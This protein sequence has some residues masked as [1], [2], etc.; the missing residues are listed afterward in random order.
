MN[1]IRQL[2]EKAR[3]IRKLVITSV[4]KA[5]S[6]HPGG[7]LSCADLMA[8]LYFEVMNVRPEEPRWEDRDRFVLS[9]GHSCPALYAA[10]A[11]R[12][13]FPVKELDTLRCLGSV[14][15]GHP[16]SR[17]TPG[18]DVSAGS[19]GQ[20]LSIS[21]GIA[22]G[23]KL[24]HKDFYIYCLMGDGETEEGQIWEAAMTA[25]HYGLDHV[26]AFVDYNHLQI[27]GTIEEVIGNFDIAAK[28]RA[29]GWRTITVDGHNME[30][31]INAIQMAKS[32]RNTPACIILNTVKG[33]GVSFM[34][35]QAAW[36]GSAPTPQQTAC[37][38]SELE[39]L[40]WGK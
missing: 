2:E 19:L 27:D 21:N 14:L 11:L 18:V 24:D 32:G 40:I 12:G 23:A 8:V 25:A 28:F 35:N 39:G 5:K 13:Y 36:H 20:G 29:F 33:K 9:K 30:E 22:M 7:A 4:S 10:L 26:I 3:E 15:Q 17:K 16:C 6:G 37:A 1:N 31:I 38:L 34:E